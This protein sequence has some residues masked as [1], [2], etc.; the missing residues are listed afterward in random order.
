MSSNSQGAGPA[1]WRYVAVAVLAVL[2]GAV[3]APHIGNVVSGIGHGS[4]DAVAVVHVEGPIV[5]QTA[6][7][8]R[9][10]LRE[11]RQN[12]TVRAVVLDVNSPGGSVAASESLYM[13]VDRT[14]SE[15]PVVA[16]V[17]ETGASGAYMAMLP[18]DRIYVKPGSLVGSVGVIAQQPVDVGGNQ[19]TSGPDKVTGFTDEEVVAMV[20]TLRRQFVGMV[21]AERDDRLE[22][23]REEVSNA[24]VYAG[25]I[26]V[27][28]GMADRVGDRGSAVAHAADRAGLG[29]YAIVERRPETQP[30]V[31]LLG[32]R[33]LRN[34]SGVVAA[35]GPFDYRGV[36]TTRLLA[37]WGTPERGGADR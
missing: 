7:E 1:T 22:L 21:V 33:D 10:H 29:E 26:A 15:M 4:A 25:A 16:S 31:L 5:S 12:D 35:D 30:G 18:A 6:A 3:L 19:V 28:N 11:A 34:A 13:A 20:E 2:I 14:A 36:E 37:L 27:E 9:E 8:T 17:D 23:T 32:Q 24:K